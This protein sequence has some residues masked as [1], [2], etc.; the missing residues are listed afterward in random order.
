MTPTVL[1]LT[2]HSA[3][4][5]TSGGRVR[6]ANLIPRLARN[7]RL[8]V[9]AVSRTPVIDQDALDGL[10]WCAP[11]RV[12]ADEAPRRPYPTR[13]SRRV[14]ELLHRMGPH[15]PFD[16]V[17]VEGHY[18]LHLVP[19]G[20]SARVVLVEHNIESHLLIQRAA[21]GAPRGE[22][23][24][25]SQD[26]AD[27]AEVRRGE[28]IAWRRAAVVLTLSAE[29]RARLLARE[30]S[31]EV[32]VVRNGCDHVPAGE[33]APNP[34][35][36][37][38]PARIGFLANF[39]YGPNLD[40]LDWLL[41]EILPRLRV[42]VPRVELVL[43]GS[44]SQEVVA[45]RDLPEGVQAAGWIDDLGVW[46]KSIDVMVCPLRIGGGIKVKVT[47]AVRGG[48]CVVS[49]SVGVEG[50]PARVRD[51]VLA[52]D[53]AD[54]LAAGLALMCTDDDALRASLRRVADRQR[55]LPTWDDAAADVR[56]HW[57]AVARRPRGPA[58]AD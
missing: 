29:D 58:D 54:G 4:P 42:A 25:T 32:R 14:R 26:A 6:D 38:I 13:D 24:A 2:H 37:D 43:A 33:P 16:V 12:F 19:P 8:E 3:W 10:G 57:A 52:A 55:Y 28:A 51:A 34:R 44:Q 41:D 15:C 20:W 46:W 53:T 39:G 56:R 22:G 48:C 45:D 31:V 49:T 18:L 50:L 47:E 1:Y 36:P 40:A 5:T 27:L 23:R 11:V 35:D 7:A 9:W 21:L 30:P 17:H